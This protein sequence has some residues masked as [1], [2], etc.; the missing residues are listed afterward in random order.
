MPALAQDGTGYLLTFG[1]NERLEYQTNP[2]LD[3]G[4]SDDQI[5]SST[6]LSFGILSETRTQRLRFDASTALR[7]I[8]NNEEGFSSTINNPRLRLNYDR[9]GPRAD[10]SFSANYRQDD[11][12]FIRPFDDFRN[13]EGIIVL[14]EDFGDLQGSGLRRS[15][16]GTLDMTFRKDAPLSFVVRG[17]LSQID[18]TDVT[19][20]NLNDIRRENLSVSA[21]FRFSD[22]T[23]GR[24]T[25]SYRLYNEAGDGGT[26]RQ[27]YEVRFGLNHEIS[28][29]L[30]ID[31]TLGYSQVDTT[32]DG[33][34]RTSDKPVGSIGLL[35]QMPNG[36]LSFDLDTR[37]ESDGV[38]TTLWVGRVMQLTNGGLTARVGVTDPVGISIEPVAEI[39]WNRELPSGQVNASLVRS[40]SSQQDDQ[41]RVSSSLSLGYN[42]SFNN[43]SG[44]GLDFLVAHITETDENTVDRADISAFYRR[45]L[46]EDWNLNV[47]ATWTQRD[48]ATVGNAESQSVFLTIGRNW[49]FRP[50]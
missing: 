42:Y 10:L 31:G 32:E 34:S 26:D 16:G 12:D 15:Y 3:V 47:G 22:T 9:E 5:E 7:L 13:D 21:R 49:S 25:P 1:L 41:T 14:P 2:D 37:A 39:L 36:T 50:F 33:T 8:D 27:T 18:Y 23:T 4:S 17:E 43:V 40:V 44:I 20:P 30:S 46:T 48:E 35:Q 19:D 24:I 6:R 29:S 11:V 45:A 38:W 28:E